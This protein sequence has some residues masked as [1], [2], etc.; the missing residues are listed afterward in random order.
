MASSTHVVLVPSYNPGPLGLAAVREARRFW[1]PVYVI[2]DGSTDGTREALL[3]EAESDP[4]LRVLSLS[5]NRGKGAAVL[6]GLEA[7]AAAGFTH[8]L[9]MDGD[10]QH[11]ADRIADFMAASQA[12]PDAMILGQPQFGSEA[13]RVRVRGRKLSNF[14]THVETLGRRIGD[15]L[16]GFRVYPIA[17]L[18]D[19]MRAVPW[20][21]R[22]D[23]D[24]EAAVRLCWRGVRTVNIPAT[25]RYFR[26]EEGGVSHFH[27]VRDNVLL[28]AMHAR[29]VFG[30][31]I[32]LP[33]LL[34]R[35]LRFL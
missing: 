10:G 21:R 25:V 2:V 6:H 16:F 12:A 7:A 30:T 27:Y 23:F 28:T 9:V 31:L 4:G 15:S 35:R 22:F 33:L 14:F 24:A 19:V 18:L 8:A 1:N 17:P 20:M 13:P 34:A 3:A 5:R 29:L 11:P 32:R 26:R